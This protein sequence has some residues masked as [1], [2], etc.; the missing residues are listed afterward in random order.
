MTRAIIY[1]RVNGMSTRPHY[2][3]HISGTVTETKP[4]SRVQ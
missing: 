1:I 4:A 2:S 3:S